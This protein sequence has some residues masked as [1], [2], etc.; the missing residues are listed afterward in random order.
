MG[1]WPLRNFSRQAGIAI[2]RAE[3]F[4]ATL[5]QSVARSS[6]MR[7]STAARCGLL[8][9]VDMTVK[10]DGAEPGRIGRIAYRPQ[11]TCGSAD[12]VCEDGSLGLYSWP[13]WRIS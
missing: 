13:I 11:A 6:E 2:V 3:S 7:A 5:A 4:S 1:F 8:V 9:S 10:L 12:R